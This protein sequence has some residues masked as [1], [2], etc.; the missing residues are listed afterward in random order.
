VPTSKN[1]L[2]IKNQKGDKSTGKIVQVD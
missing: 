1:V 2:T